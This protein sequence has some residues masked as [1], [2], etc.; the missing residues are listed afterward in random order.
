M[1][2]FLF[3]LQKSHFVIMCK[4]F[5]C[6]CALFVPL[7]IVHTC[8]IWLTVFLFFIEHIVIMSRI[9]LKTCTGQISPVSPSSAL[10]RF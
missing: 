5:Y 3:N 2:F 4:P 8:R 10:Q 6:T 1:N 9:N 7:F